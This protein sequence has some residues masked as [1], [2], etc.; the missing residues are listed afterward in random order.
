MPAIERRWILRSITAITWLISIPWGIQ[1]WKGGEIPYEPVI[2]FFTGLGA[3]IASFFM[4]DPQQTQNFGEKRLSVNKK[5]TP[6]ENKY[7]A[8]ILGFTLSKLA[9]YHGDPIQL[10]SL[11]TQYKLTMHKLAIDE[12]LAMKILDNF[13]STSGLGDVLKNAH[14][15]IEGRNSLSI[16]IALQYNE[17]ISAAFR[18]GY[19]I[20]NLSPRLEF[21]QVAQEN[22]SL[23]TPPFELLNTMHNQFDSLLQ[24]GELLK[25]HMSQLTRLNEV[26]NLASNGK[27]GQAC[28]QLI[29]IG[30]EIER[31][32]K[33][34]IN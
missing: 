16:A 19:N 23:K 29:S 27:A 25:L 14:L 7:L 26:R 32:F 15:G 3:L 21:L 1:I 22:P 18:L 5:E 17:E 12:G 33:A 4:N 6:P 34:V 10:A 13:S 11:K 20:I 2:T 24:D 31:Q 9:W 8:Y 30:S 28:D